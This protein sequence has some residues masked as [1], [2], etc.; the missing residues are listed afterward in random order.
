[1]L[2]CPKCGKELQD[3]TK[4]CDN[5]GTQIFETIFCPNCGAQTSTEFKFCQKCGA[6]IEEEAPAPA[7]EEKAQKP[8]PVK[9]V[10]K[11]T[12]MLG[13]VGVVAVLAII[14]VVSMFTGGGSKGNYGL[15][16][17]DSEIFYSDFSG[18][19][20][21]LTSRLTQSFSGSS[22]SSYAGQLADYI[23]FSENGKRVFFPDRLDNS[24]GGITLYY[25][26]LNKPD[27]EATKIDSDVV[28]YAINAAGDKVVYL[29]GQDH[30][31][32]YIHDLTDKEKIASDVVYFYVNDDCKKVSYRT[33]ENGYYVWNQG[34]DSVKLASDVASVEYVSD[35]LSQVYYTKDG[36]LYKQVENSEDK[37]KIASD[38]SRV[39]QISE[40][41]E[42]YYTKAE[43]AQ[44]S[45]MDYVNDDMA[46]A[47]AA[48]T[49]PEYPE[50]PAS[51]DY[52]YSWNYDTTE[53]YEA[54]WAEYEAAYEQYQATCDQLREEYNKAY[55][56]YRDKL[57]RDSM[58]ESLKNDT[59]D[60]TVYSLYCY[61]G[62]EETL[63][64]D[65][66]TD[67]WDISKANNAPVMVVQ[68]YDQA[69]V[70]KVNLSEVE[71]YYE[72][73]E[74]VQDALYSSAKW[75]VLSG[76]TLS[77]VTQNDAQSFILSS[78]GTTGYFLD[79]VDEEGV[80]DLY[81]L[82]LS[83]DKAGSSELYD[84]DV[85]AYST[86]SIMSNN[87][88]GY[89]KN[90]KDDSRGDLFIDG[91]EVDYDVRISWL[92]NVDGKVY[93]YTDW[94]SERQYGTL[95]CFSGKEAQKVADDVHDY[96][97][98]PEKDILYLYD[99]SSNYY[100]GTLYLY[101]GGKAE[102]LDDDVIAL[103]PVWNTEIKGGM[104]YGW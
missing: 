102:K 2:T 21:E 89:Y 97:V 32:L 80:G 46:A 56:E 39:V 65:A 78:D 4:F 95:K 16:L 79:D 69:E 64:T 11:K 85:S 77:V 1:M 19:P 70:Q 72:V 94:N 103:I 10:P 49:Q 48:I 44:M 84:S 92:S 7:Q 50:Y 27:E 53:A 74:M 37:E 33:E 98:T 3:G 41:G 43:S 22:L 58:R 57:S 23:A 61:N 75:Y 100:T 18:D 62:S 66:L 42:V 40:S 55:E 8:N 5:C 51:P 31:V 36:S 73:R 91:K 25:R 38:V 6:S 59:M 47:D 83:G 63:I 9:A 86:I 24:S 81:R 90:V 34:K 87:Q 14:L 35:D 104:Y 88:V 67:E 93:Y 96:I 17:K 29:K 76:T 28:M 30:S 71:S 15:Y 82:T 99:Y 26:N 52:P 60:S 20:M 68:V 54:A 12:L 45:L 13:A 101:K